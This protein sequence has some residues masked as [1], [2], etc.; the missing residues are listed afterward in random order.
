M[1]LDKVWMLVTLLQFFLSAALIYWACEYFVN[2]VEW[3]GKHLRL[4]SMA[5]G[6]V[7][8]AFGTALPESSVTFIAVV[9]GR[10]AVEKDLGVGAALG[11]PLV[12]ATLAY[13]VVGGTLLLN[14]RGLGRKDSTV[15]VDDRSLSRD[16]GLFLLL[17]AV[18]VLLGLTAFR[19]KS[20]FGLL[21]VAAYAAYAYR[22]MGDRRSFVEGSDLEPLK[23]RHRRPSLG[24]AALQTILALGVIGVASHLFVEQLGAMAAAFHWP[25]QMAAL[26]LSPMAT[27]LPETMNALIWVRQGKERLALAN[28]SGAMVIQATIP[29]AL[30]LL[31]TAWR[32]D[33]SLLISGVVTLAAMASLWAVFRRGAVQARALVPVCAFYG[34]FA[35]AT[36]YF[37]VHR[38][39]HVPAADHLRA[40]PVAGQ[41]EA[42][43]AGAKVYRQ[44]CAGCHRPSA[45]G[46]REGHPSLRNARLRKATDGDIEWFLRQGE[47]G[48]G[49]PSW[50][51]LPESERWQ[52]VTYLKSIQ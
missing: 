32:F 44:R 6:A 27:E 28:I 13:A 51:S 36:A 16:Q 3:C 4:G 39:E 26:I 18:N 33:R 19:C 12:L 25:S 10:N 20:L 2:G 30:G 47:M 34:L 45:R 21:S 23:I 11:G 38:W 17:F 29:S 35:V 52:I 49:M 7:L 1:L 46:D 9:F 43:A 5:I 15:Q 24:W 8:A 40:N 50:V 48:T 37:F 14:R 41:S 42:V 22:K 31:F